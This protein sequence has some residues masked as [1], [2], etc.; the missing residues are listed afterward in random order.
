MTPPTV[1]Q[2]VD[3]GDVRM[4]ERGQRPRLTEEALARLRIAVELRREHLERHVTF[5]ARIARE[6]DDAH[7]STPQLAENRIRADRV[8]YPRT[9]RRCRGPRR[10][11]SER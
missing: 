1:F 3:G 5:E 8:R 2:R 11:T 10:R 9:G 6:I 7:A 4:V